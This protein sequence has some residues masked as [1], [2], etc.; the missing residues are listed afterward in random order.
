MKNEEFIYG[1]GYHTIGAIRFGQYLLNSQTNEGKAETLR[2]VVHH[3]TTAQE[4]LASLNDEGL[5]RRSEPCEP[6]TMDFS[7]DK[8]RSIAP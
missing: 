6:Y 5:S 1:L 2:K 4:L 7:D 8:E 3:L